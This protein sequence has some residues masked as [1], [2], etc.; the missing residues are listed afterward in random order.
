MSVNKIKH[1]ILLILLIVL[2]F[3]NSNKDYN[4]IKKFPEV[5]YSTMNGIYCGEMEELEV[6][7]NLVLYGGR[8]DFL[9]KYLECDTCLAKVE[10]LFFSKPTGK[11]AF[12]SLENNTSNSVTYSITLYFWDNK[13]GYNVATLEA[14]ERKMTE[15]ELELLYSDYITSVERRRIENNLYFKIKN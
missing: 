13:R 11:I 5:D 14:W 8:N 3:C 2:T 1:L 10:S 6:N 4:T 9:R 15:K 7:D 12:L